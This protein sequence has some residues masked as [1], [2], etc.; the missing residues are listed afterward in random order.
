MFPN[1]VLSLVQRIHP[2]LSRLFWKINSWCQF[3]VS[4]RYVCSLRMICASYDHN[5]PTFEVFLSLFF[6]FHFFL[7]MFAKN[8]TSI[9]I[10]EKS[11]FSVH[12]HSYTRKKL[13]S[14]YPHALKNSF[15]L[16]RHGLYKIS[17]RFQRFP[18]LFLIYT[19]CFI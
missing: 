15:S 10:Y 13:F 12:L 16:Y 17:I 1:Y 5:M 4:K 8:Y 2:F 14:L 3:L 7:C 6:L 9:A 19:H 18:F 11:F